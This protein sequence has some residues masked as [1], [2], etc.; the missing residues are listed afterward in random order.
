[1][2]VSPV[3]PAAKE[4]VREG[5]FLLG[6]LALVLLAVAGGEAAHEGV[7][8]Q[9]RRADVAA[10]AGVAFAVRLGGDHEAGHRHGGSQAD[11]ARDLLVLGHVNLR[12]TA[13]AFRPGIN[14][15]SRTS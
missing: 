8:V 10:G 6:L 11:R 14:L 4:V 7:V 3:E 12:V 2:A 5:G 1:W 13:G 9:F 15:D